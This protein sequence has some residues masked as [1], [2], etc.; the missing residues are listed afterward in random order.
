MSQLNFNAATVEPSA[1]LEPLPTGWY[2]MQIVGSDMKPTARGD[3][4]Y[5]ELELQVIDGEFQG[6][7]VFDRLNLNNP[8][9]TAVEI[10][11]RTLSAICHATNVIQ[12]ND[13]TEL[14]NKPME[15]R[16][17][18]KAAEGDY[19][20]SNNVKGYRAVNGGTGGQQPQQQQGWD[21]GQQQAPQQQAPQQQPQQNWQQ[22]QQQQGAP[23]QQQQGGWQQSSQQPPQQGFAQQP[24]QQQQAPQQQPQADAGVMP[25]QNQPQQQSQQQGQGQPGPS[26]GQN[27]NAAPWQQ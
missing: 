18:V 3:G 2:T 16:V 23:Q 14:H 27:P 24:Q 4:S 6:R 5:L 25:Q 17:T 21:Q 1:A 10:A 12:V 9:P 22:P 19:D 7:K 15:V 8:N 11:N 13:S 20:A 26:A